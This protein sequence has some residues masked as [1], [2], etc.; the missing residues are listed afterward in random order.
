MDLR[1]KL[2]A[3]VRPICE[4]NGFYL[5]EVRVSG[6]SHSPVFQVFA[7]NE[8]GITVDECARLSRMIQ[9]ELDMNDDFGMNYR[10]DVSSPGLDHPLKYDWEFK[11]NV[12]RHLVVKYR[13]EEKEWRV[14]G[15]LTDF[16]AETIIL[17]TKRGTMEIK[18]GDIE[19]AKVKVQW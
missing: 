6:G 9:D 4:N 16:N 11:K 5:L 10:L 3:I 19:Q 1:E 7:D 12:G 2:E 15:K 17:E 14:T 18:R 13:I 8:R